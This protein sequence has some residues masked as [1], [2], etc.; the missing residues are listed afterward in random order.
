VALQSLLKQ[1]ALVT[2]PGETQIIAAP[3]TIYGLD[4]YLRERPA[5]NEL[6]PYGELR[7]VDRRPEDHPT[8]ADAASA[9]EQ[10]ATPD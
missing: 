7:P 6:R 5:V 3:D 2:I 8:A 9:T 1:R 10:L 4:P